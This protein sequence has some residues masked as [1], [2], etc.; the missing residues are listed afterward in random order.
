MKTKVFTLL[1]VL[2]GVMT[3]SLNAQ[4]KSRK[5]MIKEEKMLFINEYCKFTEG[6]I[7]KFWPLEDE[8]QSKMRE[9]KKSMRRELKDIKDKGVDNVSETDLKKAMDN[10]QM[11][12]QKLLDIKW[13]YNQKFVDLVGVKKTAKFYEGEMA[14]RKK[15]IDRLKDLKM[16]RLGGDEDEDDN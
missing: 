5:E 10:R 11:Y 3:M 8:M 12:E 14:F 7:G 2:V 15:L 4:T 1:M 6:E 13:E 9:V 16:D